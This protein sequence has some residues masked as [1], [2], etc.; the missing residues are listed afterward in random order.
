M[1]YL[2]VR[3]IL[4]AN[5]ISHEL[6]DEIIKRVCEVNALLP[7]LLAIKK[8]DHWSKLPQPLLLDAIRIYKEEIV[9]KLT[10]GTL[11][12]ESNWMERD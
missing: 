10:T 12:K 1:E 7:E 6:M 9:G 5:N 4:K 3:G 2:E 8:H 11:R